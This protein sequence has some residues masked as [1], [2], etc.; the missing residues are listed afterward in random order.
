MMTGIVYLSYAALRL[1][2]RPVEALQ[3]TGV[4]SFQSCP[5]GA[6]DP[7]RNTDLGIGGE[8]VDHLV[9]LAD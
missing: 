5:P 2:D 6:D 3:R 4:T 9:L 8:T 7:H 1:M